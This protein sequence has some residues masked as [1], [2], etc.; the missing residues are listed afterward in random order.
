MRQSEQCYRDLYEKAPIAY[1]TISA[2]DGSIINCN[3]AASQ[4]LGYDKKSIIKKKVF[5][6]YADTP[7]GISKAKKVF[8][9]FKAG[10]AIRDVELQMQDKDGNP[11]WISLSVEPIRDKDGNVIESR[12][13]AININKRKRAEK[14]LQKSEEELRFLSSRLLTIQEEER[15]QIARELHDGIGQFLNFLIIGMTNALENINKQ[16]ARQAS[17]SL[18]ALIPMIK[19]TIKEIRRIY[20][21]LRPSIIDNLGILATIDWFCREFEETCPGIRIEKQVD[22]EEF[23]FSDILKI[24]V[25]RILQEGFNNIVKYS[26]ADLV[27]LSLRETEGTIELAIEDNG[28]GFDSKDLLSRKDFRKGIGL[29][30][31]RERTELSGGSFVI[32]SIKGKGTTIQAS[33][34]CKA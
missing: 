19:N 26:K 33:W 29:T 6:L 3:S 13:T 23:E 11:I 7:H 8:M 14:A 25:F 27:R 34:P 17:E 21:D 5:D 1:F 16:A 15:K 10:R 20:T 9:A 4:L 31:M 12:S 2:I 22:I 32:K 30:S 18:Q 24:T 28:S